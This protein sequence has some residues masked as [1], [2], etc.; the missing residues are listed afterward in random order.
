MRGVLN[1]LVLAACACVPVYSEK[2][3]F[4]QTLLP[5]TQ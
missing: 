5:A 1:V 3:E 2:M 4:S